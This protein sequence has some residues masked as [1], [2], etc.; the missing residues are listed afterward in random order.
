MSAK[1]NLG[2]IGLGAMGSYT[3]SVAA[4]HPDVNLL[5]CADVDSESVG[6]AKDNY[7]QIQFTT[8]PSDVI[9]SCSYRPP[10]GNADH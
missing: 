2:I 9:E 10:A 1:I 5:L 3:L 6:R 8:S 7:P 4:K